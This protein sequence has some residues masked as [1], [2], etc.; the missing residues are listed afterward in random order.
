M[1]KGEHF[2]QKENFFTAKAQRPAPKHS[3]PL[4]SSVK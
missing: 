2:F 1:P 3:V 4:I